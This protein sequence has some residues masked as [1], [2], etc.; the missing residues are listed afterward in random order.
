[1]TLKSPDL[2][3]IGAGAAGLMCAI[4]AGKKILMSAPLA[5]EMKPVVDE[6][7]AEVGAVK[8]YDD[9]MKRYESVPFTPAIDADLSDYVVE[10]GKE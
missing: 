2:I 4:T 3:V 8:M 5:L 7:L 1:M 6:S 9:V 10:K